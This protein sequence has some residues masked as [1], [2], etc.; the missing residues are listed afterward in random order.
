M[1]SRFKPLPTPH[2]SVGVCVHR[3][4]WGYYIEYIGST[5]ALLAAGCITQL[6]VD[7]LNAPSGA[8]IDDEGNAFH[9]LRRPT[10]SQPDRCEIVRYLYDE[11][12]ALGLPGVADHLSTQQ[13]EPDARP[14]IKTAAARVAEATG[15]KCLAERTRA[16]GRYQRVVSW[17][18]AGNLVFPD[19]PT[20]RACA[21]ADR[22][23]VTP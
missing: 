10:K 16:V 8:Y 15:E 17:V 23:G 4:S 12:K 1:N 5:P 22:A 9:R 14:R 3:Q 20:I 11:A 7:I 2:D 13:P 6:M 19:W 21:V 18:S